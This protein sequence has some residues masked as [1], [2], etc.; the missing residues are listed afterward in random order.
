LGSNA[1]P[2]PGRHNR[3]RDPGVFDV[4]VVGVRNLVGDAPSAAKKLVAPI[5][6]H[7]A[8]AYNTYIGCIFAYFQIHILLENFLLLLYKFLIPFDMAA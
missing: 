3:D 1:K 6:S 5:I 7:M 4:E 2:V 8:I